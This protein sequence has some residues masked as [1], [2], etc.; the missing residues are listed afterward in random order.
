MAAATET[1]QAHVDNG[2]VVL[3]GTSQ[4]G[5]DAGADDLVVASQVYHW[6]VILT[7]M[8]D[9]IESGALG[10]EAMGLTEAPATPAP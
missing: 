6:E 4:S 10:G 9:Q 7:D 3:T 1:A 8:F 5:I 2:A